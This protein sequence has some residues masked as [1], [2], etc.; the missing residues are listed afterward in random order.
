MDAAVISDFKI[1]DKVLI[2]AQSNW[3][4]FIDGMRGTIERFDQGMAVVKVFDEG[5]EKEFYVPPGE[6]VQSV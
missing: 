5:I 4:E 6:L 2:T 1:G 3:C